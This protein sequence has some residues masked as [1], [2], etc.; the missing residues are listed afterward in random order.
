MEQPVSKTIMNLMRRVNGY[1]Q[2]P[3]EL[4]NAHASYDFSILVW[5]SE[6]EEEKGKA[7][8]TEITYQLHYLTSLKLS[9]SVLIA[10]SGA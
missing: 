6:G 2:A 3:R 4:I 5:E 9:S 7:R 8:T 1:K 10:P